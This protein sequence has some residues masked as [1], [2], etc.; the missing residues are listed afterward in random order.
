MFVQYQ[1]GFF[2]L[3]FVLFFCYFLWLSLPFV[4]Y[5]SILSASLLLM[6]CPSQIRFPLLVVSTFSRLCL[7]C[8]P[9]R[10]HF[11]SFAI[12]LSLLMF[13]FTLLIFCFVWKL[14]LSLFIGKGKGSCSSNTTTGLLGDTTNNRNNNNGS[15]DVSRS[16][17][18]DDMERRWVLNCSAWAARWEGKRRERG[19]GEGSG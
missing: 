9:L 14:T 8:F 4:V 17:A 10:F 16:I 19:E 1:F 6:L 18:N 12:C 3:D 13:C 11:C 2:N 7:S 5:F 15:N